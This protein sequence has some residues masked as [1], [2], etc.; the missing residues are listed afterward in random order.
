MP[1]TDAHSEEGTAGKLG[2]APR[3]EPLFA[4]A[5]A[6]AGATV[7][8]VAE[9]GVNHDG[10][11]DRALMLLRQAQQAGADAVKMQL[12]DPQWLLSNQAKLADYQKDTDDSVFEMLARLKLSADDMLA[13]RAEARRMGLAFV[14]TP[15][16]LENFDLLAD[17]HVDAVK[18]ASTDAVNLPLVKQTAALGRPM[19]VSTGA[20]DLEELSPVVARIEDRPAC[21]LHCVSS[22]PAPTEDASLGALP[23]LAERYGLAVGYSDHTNELTMG[24]LA[25]AAGACV[26]EKHV[27][28]DR[29]AYGPDHAA[30]FDPPR[31][32]HY[33]ELVRQAALILGRRAKATRSIEAEVRHLSRQSVCLV[34]DLPAGHVLERADLTIKR[35][36]TGIP[37]AQLDQVIGQRLGRDVQANDLL[38]ES[39]LG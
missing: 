24:A 3:P 7:C 26:I 23:A 28:Y 11:R 34:C 27:T 2:R 21:L 8:V 14:V 22:Y 1:T 30:S 12:F 9:I 32:A 36:G 16:S 29:H 13:L 4:P 33:I 39:D 17:L 5:T 15:F 18:I 31:F 25:V 19:I 20:T 38:G 6:T 37:A 35:P 10:R